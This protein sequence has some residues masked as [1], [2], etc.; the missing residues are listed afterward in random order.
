MGMP[1]N[2]K[3]HGDLLENTP[4]CEQRAEG[5]DKSVLV[6]LRGGVELKVESLRKENNWT[7]RGRRRY[8]VAALRTR[9]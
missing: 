7:S 2:K 4:G 5:H 9:D 3:S 1:D 6:V 8:N